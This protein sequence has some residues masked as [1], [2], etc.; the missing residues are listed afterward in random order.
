MWFCT[1][2]IPG[3]PKKCTI[4]K[5]YNLKFLHEMNMSY[6]ISAISFFKENS[7]NM[8]E[9]STKKSSDV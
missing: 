6:I 8:T 2:I 9:L 3:V 4:V 1:C 7:S 5:R